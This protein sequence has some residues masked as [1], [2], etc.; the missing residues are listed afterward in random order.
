[1]KLNSIS[2]GILLLCFCT[3][4]AV[5]KTIYFD[6]TYHKT[7]KKHAVYY[8]EI[9]AIKSGISIVEDRYMSGQLYMSG[10]YDSQDPIELEGIWADVLR[11][12]YFTYYYPS[13]A[14]KM[15]GQYKL[16]QK[17]QQWVYYYDSSE[18]V[19]EIGGYI[20][21]NRVGEWKAYYRN[22]KLKQRVT[23][24]GN[25][26][27]Y[28]TYVRQHDGDNPDKK[29][30]QINTSDC[31]N[32][33]GDLIP[34]EDIVDGIRVSALSDSK[35]PTKEFVFVNTE[36]P[37]PGYNIVAYLGKKIRYPIAAK[38]RSKG[39]K[40]LIAMNVNSDGSLT[41]I[42][43][44][45]PYVD[46]SLQMEALRVVSEMPNWQ[47]VQTKLYIEYILPIVFAID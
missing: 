33:Q 14:L 15:K 20:V 27:N 6:S 4:S 21:G 46:A 42:R 26:S 12:G 39:G 30:T 1:M 5:A 7:S 11:T 23:F 17:D 8:R 24:D 31:Y 35:E 36:M 2:V 34:C 10:Y 43:S 38:G 40:V 19:K 3:T 29:S 22:G 16:G 32:I 44:L 47:P 37:S 9:I 28:Y 41:N 13:R 18:Q 45:T 25:M